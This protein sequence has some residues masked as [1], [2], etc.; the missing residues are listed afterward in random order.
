MQDRIQAIAENYIKLKA[1][2]DY[3]VSRINEEENNLNANELDKEILEKADLIIRKV[4]LDT[5]KQLE[6]HVTEMVSLAQSTVFDEPYELVM[7]FVEKREKTECELSFKDKDIILADCLDSVGFGA[8]DVTCFALRIA[9]FTMRNETKRPVF[10]L[11][12]PFKHL[13]G[14]EAN[15]RAIKLLSEVSKDL[16]LQIITISMDLDREDIIQGA[17]SV[18]MVSKKNNISKLLKM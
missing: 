6:Y 14:K 9:S 13:K 3:H 1:T 5:Q 2:R 4:A 16:G 15:R 10:I 8:V 18:F 17:D 11:D 12:E 7:E